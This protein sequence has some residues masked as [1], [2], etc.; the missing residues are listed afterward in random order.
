MTYPEFN[1]RYASCQE[2]TP[3]F[4]LPCAY[5]AREGDINRKTDIRR[6]MPVSYLFFCHFPSPDF[7]GEGAAKLRGWG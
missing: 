4:P 5:G 1:I 7:G 3:C 2:P 6:A